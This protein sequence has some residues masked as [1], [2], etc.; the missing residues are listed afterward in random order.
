MEEILTYGLAWAGV[1]ALARAVPWPARWHERKPLSCDACMCLWGAAAWVLVSLPI[2]LERPGARRAAA[3]YGVALLTT[4][5]Y[6]W[7]APPP[8]F[9]AGTGGGLT[10]LQV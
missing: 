10:E 1:A 6:R 7:R 4:R 9:G 2:G 3:A 5:V 8:A